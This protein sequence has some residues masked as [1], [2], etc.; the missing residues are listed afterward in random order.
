MTRQLTVVTPPMRVIA[1]NSPRLE[2]VDVT[3]TAERIPSS[4]VIPGEAAPLGPALGH[5]L[6]AQ[7]RHGGQ[8]SGRAAYHS[9]SGRRSRGRSKRSARTNIILCGLLALLTIA[10][11]A[12][13][14]DGARNVRAA[15][16]LSFYIGKL[17]QNAGLGLTEVT[18]KGQR[19]TSDSAIYDRL[20][21]A[22]VHSVWFLDTQ[23]ARKRI[24]TL[25]WIERASLKRVYPDRLLISIQERTPTLVWNDGRRTVLVDATGAVLG[26]LTDKRWSHLPIVFGEGAAQHANGIIQAVSRLPDLQKRVGLYERA[27]GRRWTLHLRSGQQI[28]LPV[29]GEVLALQQ[30]MRG[31]ASQRLLDSHFEKLD[32]R[33]ASQAAI[34]FR[35]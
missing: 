33:V 19:S 31:P 25:P 21:L 11:F 32:L 28:L 13:L 7:A 3:E 9:A 16:P 4:F 34:S 30:L 17:L 15:T 18:V 35:S 12:V 1:E 6:S 26:P 5:G 27:A 29:E 14:T 8:R 20:Q 22:K 24:E 2:L 10:V 23:A